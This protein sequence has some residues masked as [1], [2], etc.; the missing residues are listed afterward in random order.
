MTKQEFT[1][2]AALRLISVRPSAPMCEILDLARNLADGIYADNGLQP[3]PERVV[4]G[5]DADEPIE[6]LLREID[7]LDAEGVRLK[8]AKGKAEGWGWNPQKSG[9]AEKVRKTCR[10]LGFENVPDLIIFGKNSFRKQSFI[11]EKCCNVVDEA[12]KNLYNITSW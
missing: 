2:E 3:E 10:W 8:K 1:Q 6:N 9:F 11:G 7:R 12:L 4:Y 5:V